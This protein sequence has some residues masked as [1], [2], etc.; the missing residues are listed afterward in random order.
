RR[1]AAQSA[2]PALRLRL[3]RTLRLS[4]GALPGRGAGGADDRC[5]PPQGLPPR[6]AGGCG[7]TKPAPL[8]EVKDL[9]VHFHVKTAGGIFGR[10]SVL[11]AVDGASFT[12]MPGE[13]LG[14][15]GESGCGKSTL[16]RAVLQL[17][18]P[19]SGQVVW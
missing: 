6:A 11:K 15:V 19:T 1:P 9:Q 2:A 13:T 5:R 14:V 16:G 8:L 10:P 17:I 4:L 3:Q 7:V 12:L 18:P